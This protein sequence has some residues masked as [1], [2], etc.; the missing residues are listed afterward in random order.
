MEELKGTRECKIRHFAFYYDNSCLIHK[1]AKYSTSYWPQE[2]SLDQFKGTL[3]DRENLYDLG[4]NL[5]NIGTYSDTKAVQYIYFAK[6][7]KRT[8][9]AA[10][11]KAKIENLFK[12]LQNKEVNTKTVIDN[13]VTGIETLLDTMTIASQ[14]GRE[15]DQENLSSHNDSV[16]PPFNKGKA[17]A[18]EPWV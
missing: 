9:Q 18:K 2:L 7:A 12:T 1:E 17:K 13:L 10:L 6:R 15:S 5:D 16:T 14:D 8:L 4:I 11:E 3:K